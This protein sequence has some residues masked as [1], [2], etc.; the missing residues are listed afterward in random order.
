[1]GALETYIIITNHIFRLIHL[2]WLFIQNLK[3]IIKNK[4]D[5]S[6]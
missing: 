3:R 6:V 2:Q 5:I 4:L 1:M